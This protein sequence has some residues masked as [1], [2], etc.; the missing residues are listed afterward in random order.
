[1]R[2]SSIFAAI[3]VLLLA[4]SAGLFPGCGD[5]EPTQPDPI[6]GQ[7]PDFS[8]Q[9]VNPNSLT[10]SQAVSPRQHLGKVSAWYFA[11]AT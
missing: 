4:A 1:M 11:H 6:S 7:V 5:D 3:L 8:V 10:Y 2:A 9:D